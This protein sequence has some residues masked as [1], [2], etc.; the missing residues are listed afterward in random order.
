M[1]TAILHIGTEKTGTTTIQ[2]FLE[3][4]RD[5]LPSLGFVYPSSCGV[6]KSQNLLFHSMPEERCE[7]IHLAAGLETIERRARF[8]EE[9]RRAF[10]A[11]ME[12]LPDGVRTVIFS[13][14]HC[15]SRLTDKRDIARLHGL[16]APFFDELRVIVYLRRQDQLATSL[17]STVVR[18]G[19]TREAVL[20]AV[21]SAS[22][23]YNYQ[24]LLER[25]AEVFS[26]GM[27]SPRVF[28]RKT[29]VGGDL[30]QD[31]AAACGLGDT[32][33]LE[34]PADRN[35]GIT[36]AAQEFLRHLNLLDPPSADG[37][38]AADRVLLE[39]LIFR[40]LTGAGR[41]PSRDAA[42]RFR[43]LFDESNERVRQRWFPRRSSLFD[44]DFSMYP[45]DEEGGSGFGDAVVVSTVIIRAL[46]AEL[47]FRC[48]WIARM[49]KDRKGAEVSL[50][51]ALALDPDH[52]GA[53][54]MLEKVAK[55]TPARG[56][57]LFRRGGRRG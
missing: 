8:K 52:E 36:A 42:I 2:A 46:E 56:L 43:S 33:R 23:Y 16:L 5:R 41:R 21:D 27:V 35:E 28:D 32:R 38:R 30:V 19:E 39:E 40:K 13:D 26:E 18:G 44:D 37:T 22:N 17:Y 14:E 50:R 48:G 45:V 54:R 49:K 57:T 10:A 3:Q 24:L 53:R 31:F 6:Q 7:D 9:F 11:E 20:P 1:R 47:A 29:F 15:H 25:W 12:G 55:R 34:R 4:N 51:A